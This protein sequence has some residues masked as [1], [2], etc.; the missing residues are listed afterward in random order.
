MYGS[1]EMSRVCVCVCVCVCAGTITIYCNVDGT[2]AGGCDNCDRQ[3][4]G[5]VTS[6]ELG[7]EAR[8]LLSVVSTPCLPLAFAAEPSPGIPYPALS[9]H[10]LLCVPSPDIVYL[11]PLYWYS[12]L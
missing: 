7:V 1:A 9:S 10:S 4:N 3:R 8:M 2:D 6:R 5:E 11:R 12:K